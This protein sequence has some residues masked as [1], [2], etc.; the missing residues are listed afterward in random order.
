M[1]R[2]VDE[3]VVNL[4]EPDMAFPALDFFI[5]FELECIEDLIVKSLYPSLTVNMGECCFEENAD[6]AFL[7]LSLAHVGNK[8]DEEIK[9]IILR[10]L[11]SIFFWKI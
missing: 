2:L 5:I 3:P 4:D 7:L 6:V 8:E 11:R 1:G 9:I 10:K